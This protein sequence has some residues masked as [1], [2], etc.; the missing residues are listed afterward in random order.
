M[1]RKEPQPSPNKPIS[2]SGYRGDGIE[3]KGVTEKPVHIV[4]PSP[5][6]PPPQKK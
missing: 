4:K 6:P 3:E 2:P 1:G 5:P